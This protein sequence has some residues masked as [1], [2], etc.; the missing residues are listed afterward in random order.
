M[1]GKKMIPNET[2]QILKQLS[3]EVLENIASIKRN[4]K[5]YQSLRV[6][7]EL[8][9]ALD[10]QS[11]VHAAG[12]VVSMDSLINNASQQSFYRGRVSM[13]ILLNSLLKLSAEMIETK[14]EGKGGK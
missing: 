2:N 4:D 3:V 1:A 8:L 13:C 7:L 11:I 6:L 9:L 5:L 14:E 12:G 10:N